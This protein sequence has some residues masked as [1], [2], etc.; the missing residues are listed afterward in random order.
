MTLPGTLS[1]DV[2]WRFPA[3][4]EALK[5]AATVAAL[6]ASTGFFPR[7][8]LALERP[9]FDATRL[10]EALRLAGAGA[11]TESTQV[12]ITAPDQAENGAV[13]PF[14]LSTPLTGV[15]RLLLLVEKNPA[16][17]VADFEVSGSVEPAFSLRARM[18]ESCDVYAVAL[19]ADGRALYARKQVRVEL[20]GCD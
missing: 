8:S 6:L 12:S 15:Q 14:A 16:P 3:R 9:A 20:S 7:F 13:V 17:L 19:M 18:R 11:L 4:R 2:S 1:T 5:R 10:Q